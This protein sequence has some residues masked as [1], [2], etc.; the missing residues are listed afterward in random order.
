M[1][2]LSYQYLT[3]TPTN[4]YV[5]VQLSRGKANAL[6]QAM[7]DEL[8]D[9]VRYATK[10]AAIAG[11]LLTGHDHFFSGG[12]DLLEVFHYDSAG[13]RHFWGSFI[14]LATE[15][16][17]FPKPLVAAITGHSPAGGCILACACDYRVMAENDRY[18][19]GLNEMAV[20]IAPRKGILELYA[21]WIGR[22]TAYHYLLEGTI[23]TGEQALAIGLVDRLC[24]LDEVLEVAEK[25]LQRYLKLPQQA[26]QQTKIA[27]KASVVDALSVN[28]EADLDNLHQQLMSEE[29][30]TIMGGVVK[31]LQQRKQGV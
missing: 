12:V 13:V 1:K 6:H 26:F 10:E 14:Q 7:V 3:I 24:P 9:F 11:V 20:G 28:F 30:R 17:A 19:I 2:D 29:S 15:L 18:Q 5:I 16:V 8:R 23:M 31:Y 22:K 25:K 21:F 4:N 27:L